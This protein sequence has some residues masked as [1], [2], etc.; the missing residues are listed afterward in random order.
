MGRYGEVWG[1]VDDLGRPGNSRGCPSRNE[2]CT[3]RTSSPDAPALRTR[4]PRGG[5]YG[6]MW[7]DMGSPSCECA[8]LGGTKAVLCSVFRAPREDS[9]EEDSGIQCGMQRETVE[10]VSLECWLR[11]VT[12]L[13]PSRLTHP[14]SRPPARARRRPAAEGGALLA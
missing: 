10:R 11:D 12:T 4:Q 6:E 1:D 14:S 7:G 5:R 13:S 9:G 2:K 3:I 8:N